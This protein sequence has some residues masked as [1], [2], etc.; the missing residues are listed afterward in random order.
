[1]TKHDHIKTVVVEDCAE[2]VVNLVEHLKRF[3]HISIARTC[4][5]GEDGLKAVY[6]LRP[7]LLFLD[8]ELPDMTGL[9]FMERLDA[10]IQ[11]QC[12]IIVYTSY[13]DYM[14][15]SF[16]NNAFDFLLKPIKDDDLNDI[17][18]RLQSASTP[19]VPKTDGKILRTENNL[20]MFI[21]ATDFQMVKLKDIGLFQY[22]S[23]SRTWEIIIANR[24]KPVSLKRNVTGKTI[25]SLDSHF[26]QVNQK[27][28]INIEY[29]FQVIDNTC[30]FFPPFQNIDYVKV[31]FLYRS[32]LM[33]T[34]INL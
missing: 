6:E 3:P 29:L 5:N 9:E 2:D 23:K 4:N 15:E 24:N 16:R 22:N 30:T 21:N 26:L 14:L 27:Y 20:L 7:D 28:I 1:M 18:R 12:Q 34:F 13:V 19:T 33:K 11:G 25:L 32:R 10:E 17:M 31:G 8:I